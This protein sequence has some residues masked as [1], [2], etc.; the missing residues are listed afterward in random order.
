MSSLWTPGGER[1]VAR[2]TEPPPQQYDEQPVDEAELQARMAELRE[3]LAHT[4]VEGI[5]AQMAYQLFEI[6]ALHLSVQP[7]QFD[8]AQ[9]AIDALAQLVEGM[10]DR[11][12]EHAAPLR[13]GLSQIRMAFVQIKEQAHNAGA[14]PPPEP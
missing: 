11:L 6:G 9:L 10:G 2:E 8:Q 3:Q 7:P 12:G 1:P 5:V 13:D 14:P 4:P